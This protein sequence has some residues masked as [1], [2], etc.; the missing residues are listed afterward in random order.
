MTVA[1]VGEGFLEESSIL[2][3]S[4]S[5]YREQELNYDRKRISTRTVTLNLKQKGFI[6]GREWEKS[7]SDRRK[8]LP[9]YKRLKT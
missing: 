2:A 4:Y 7:N 3:K 8:Y 9:H 6:G 1:R 5:E